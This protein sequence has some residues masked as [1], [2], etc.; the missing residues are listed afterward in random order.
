MSKKKNGGKS[1]FGRDD[2]PNDDDYEIGYCRPPKHSQFKPGQ[3]GNRK[4]RPRGSQ[5]L[6]T[7]IRRRLAQRIP[8]REAGKMRKV[9]TLEAGVARLVDKAISR[10]DHRALV[11]LFDFARSAQVPEIE[12]GYPWRDILPLLTVDELR[13]FERIAQRAEL[14]LK[15]KKE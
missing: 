2:P 8:M 12:E 3:S 1:S 4:G 5:N 9:S 14:V 15:G 7:I 10:G 11:L 6:D 13:F